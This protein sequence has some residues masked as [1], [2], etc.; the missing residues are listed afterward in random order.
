VQVY[1]NGFEVESYVPGG[2]RLKLSGTSMSSP[3][4]ANLAG[5]ILAA[6]PELTPAEVIALIKKG[7]TP[8]PEAKKSIPLIDPKRTL[9]LL[10]E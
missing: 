3:N 10:K 1:A 6:K 2:Q 5:K 4:V 8:V 9:S 7:V